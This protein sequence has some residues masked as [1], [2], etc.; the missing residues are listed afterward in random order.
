MVH[1]ELEAELFGLLWVKEEQK[2]DDRDT[3]Q[4]R[5][6]A[7]LVQIEIQS[8]LYLALRCVRVWGAALEQIISIRYKG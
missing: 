5:K 3:P 6:P 7:T 8:V 4:K 1:Y 2:E